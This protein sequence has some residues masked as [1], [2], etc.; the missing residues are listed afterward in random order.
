MKK[1]EEQFYVIDK[2]KKVI[3]CIETN[4]VLNEISLEIYNIIQ[5]AW[6]MQF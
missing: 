5:S 4:K 3:S 2:D 6:T 1:F